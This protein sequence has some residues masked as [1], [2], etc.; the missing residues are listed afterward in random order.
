MEERN[1]TTTVA[2]IP[3]NWRRTS[4]NVVNLFRQ[5]PERFSLVV[6]GCDHT[7]SEFA[8]QTTPLLNRRIKMAIERMDRLY[9]RTSMR[10]ERVMVFPQG[11]F[12][13]ESGYAL[14]VNGFMAAANS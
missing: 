4:C 9:Q 12:S 7:A 2:F 6:H 8:T 3:W 10:Y 1:F 13:R 5:H 11:R 14:K